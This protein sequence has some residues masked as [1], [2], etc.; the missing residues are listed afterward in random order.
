MEKHLRKV[1]KVSQVFDL[2]HTNKSQRAFNI[3]LHEF[4]FITDEELE[5]RQK[6]ENDARKNAYNSFTQRKGIEVAKNF[7]LLN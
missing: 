1:K 6:A 5:K 3:M 4:G 7:G 2:A